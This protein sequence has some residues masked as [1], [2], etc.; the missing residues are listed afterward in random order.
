MRQLLLFGSA[1]LLY[2][3]VRGAA[4]GR[5]MTAEA[6]RHAYELINLERTL[7]V[8]VEPSIQAWAS[9]SHL[10]M[11]SSTW[12]YLN[13]QTTV[14]FAIL[15]YIYLRHNESFYFIRNMLIVGMTIALIGYVV[16]PTAPPRFLPEWGF[17]DTIADVAHI[18]ANSVSSNDFF[19]PY[20][21][22]PSM[23]VACA[24]MVGWPLAKLTRWRPGRVLWFL[25]PFVITFVTV[26]TANHFLSDALLGAATAGVAALVARRLARLRPQAW[27]FLPLPA[28]A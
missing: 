7:H 15:L 19:N 24:L 20:A 14:L 12:L 18:S 2:N 6:F 5:S 22:I 26:A 11:V 4:G 10:L 13:A 25:Y 21:A 27:R 8:F 1:Y 17:F 16:F 3:I 9:G 28:S 23:H